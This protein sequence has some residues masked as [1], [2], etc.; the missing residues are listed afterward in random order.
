MN[1]QSVFLGLACL[2]VLGF[3]PGLGAEHLIFSDLK[4]FSTVSSRIFWELRLPRLLL[5]VSLGGILA[6]VGG[7]YQS[8]FRNPLCEPYVL[9]ISSAVLLGVISSELFLQQSA[10]TPVSISMGV[11][12]AL[13]LVAVLTAFS[14]SPLGSPERVVLFG[15]SAN[16]VLS[17]LLFLALSVQSQNVGG[18]TL[19][20]FFGFLPWPSWKEGVWATGAALLTLAVLLSSSRVLEV[21]RLGDAV[22]R[23][24]GVAPIA[25]RNLLLVFTSL[26]MAGAVAFSGTIGFV[27]LVIPQVCRF[28]FHPK[29]MKELMLLSFVLGA[30]FL[31]LADGLSRSLLPPYEFPVGILTTLLGGPLFLW[32]LWKKK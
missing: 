26:V 19:K 20:W 28:L 9:G 12:A 22:A 31:S 14:A 2:V 8:L 13:G 32:V 11:L 23:T 18:G 16:F 4:D 17:S 30:T 5:T 21:L 3:V 10:G 15:M 24:L 25:S 7:T 6:L 1:R 29:S 27:G